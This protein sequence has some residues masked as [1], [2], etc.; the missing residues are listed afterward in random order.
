[1]SVFSDVVEA[2]VGSIVGIYLA[3][4]FLVVGIVATIYAIYQVISMIFGVYSNAKQIKN[5][6]NYKH[7]VRTLEYELE[8]A[9]RERSAWEYF[10]L[11]TESFKR[12]LKHK[13][14]YR[15]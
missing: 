1:M 2:L 5:F 7:Y 6:R 12:E 11:F 15:R 9:K 10:K 4:L 14:Q 8:F 13:L 3:A